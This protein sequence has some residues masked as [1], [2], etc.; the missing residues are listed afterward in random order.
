MSA[1]NMESNLSSRRQKPVPGDVIVISGISGKFPNAEN[2]AEL[3]Y[4]LYNKVRSLE[5]LLLDGQM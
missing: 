5:Q 3:S 4:K 1:D 2:M